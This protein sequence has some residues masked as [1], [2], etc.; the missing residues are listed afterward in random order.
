MLY[1]Y[2]DYGLTAV[3]L[4]EVARVPLGDFSLDGAHRRN[5][6]RAWRKAVD[7]GCSFELV[8]PEGVSPLLPTLRHVSNEWLASKRAREK[9]FSLGRF[10]ESFVS[11]GPVAVVRQDARIVAFGTLWRSGQKAEVEIDLMRHLDDAPPGVMRYLIVEAMLSAKEQGYAQFNLGMAPLAGIE[12]GTDSPI[13]NQIVSAVRVGG[14][15]YY[16]FQ[17][18]RD[19]KALP[20]SP[21]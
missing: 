11:A 3:K 9:S 1:R 15:R 19:F 20:T 6:R 5:L 7:A 10:T 2:L 14:E 8:P 12:S 18:I 13:W 17:G 16:N 4:G 21:P